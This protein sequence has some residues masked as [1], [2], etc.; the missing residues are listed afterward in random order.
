V[1]LDTNIV[2][3]LLAARPDV[4]NRVADVLEELRTREA[5]VISPIVYA[6]LLAGRGRTKAEVDEVL[7]EMGVQITWLLEQSIWIDAGT[8][9][10]AY[11]IRR[12]QSGGGTPRRILG[13]FVIGA[14]ALAVG[15][16][17]TLDPEFYRTNFP[18]LRVTSP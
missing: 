6:E 13:D 1:A 5:I 8:A 3:A 18:A 16:L 12:R 11:A 7:E 4:E 2:L 14:H 15:H 17:V 9:F 10:G